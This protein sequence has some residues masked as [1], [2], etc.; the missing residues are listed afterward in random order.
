MATN[1]MQD[2]QEFIPDEELRKF[3]ELNS[4]LQEAVRNSSNLLNV[5]LELNKANNNVADSFDDYQKNITQSK[6]LVNQLVQAESKQIEIEN[7]IVTVK[8]KII[9]SDTEY[10]KAL[11]QQND[12][13]QG[14]EKSY[15]QYLISNEEASRRISQL[16]KDLAEL[17][18]AREADRKSLQQLN[19]D[20]ASEKITYDQLIKQ[21]AQVITSQQVLSARYRQTS[22]ELKEL[23]A[24]TQT[25]SGSYDNLTAQYNA[26]KRSLKSIVP[27]IEEE[28]DVRERLSA[29]LKNI[30]E[31]QKQQ[32]SATGNDTLNVGN[33]KEFAST[34]QQI[35]PALATLVRQFGSLSK[36]G[37][38]TIIGA[39]VIGF[40]A[41]NKLVSASIDTLAEGSERS[42]AYEQSIARLRGGVESLRYEFKFL[43]DT[44]ASINNAIFD[45][46]S[47][48]DRLNPN[49]KGVY[50]SILQFS[51]LNTDFLDGVIRGTPIFGKYI[52]LWDAFSK[53]LGN[54]VERG[55]EA[56]MILERQNQLLEIRRESNLAIVNLESEISAQNR[57]AREYDIYTVET[58]LE[59][60]RKQRELVS[61]LYTE[62]ISI[63]KEELD[64]LKLE[65]DSYQRLNGEV[66]RS[67]L[68][69]INQQEVAL[70][71][72]Q[73][74]RDDQLAAIGR[75]TRIVLN[76][77]AKAAKEIDT[78]AK[79]Q[80]KEEEKRRREELKAEY[81]FIQEESKL[82]LFRIQNES[83]YF[84]QIF[85]DTEQSYNDRLNALYDY[86]EKQKQAV[87]ES[88][89]T[90]IEFSGVTDSGAILIREKE[91]AELL[92]LDREFNRSLALLTR[93]RVNEEINALNELRQERQNQVNITEQAELN[94]LSAS[95]QKGIINKRT[96]ENEKLE[97][98]K[99]YAEE[100]FQEEIR[101]LNELASLSNLTDTQRFNFQKQIRQ[102]ELKY[103]QDVNNAIVK[104]DEKAAQQRE[105][106]ERQLSTL[107]KQLAQEV[108]NFLGVLSDNNFNN[109]LSALK[110]EQEASEAA[111]KA[112]IKQIEDEEKSNNISSEYAQA[113]KDDEERKNTERNLRIEEEQREILTRQAKYQKAQSLV[114]A[115][116]NI[117]EAIT[118][119]LAVTP[120]PFGAPLIA[121]IGAIGA[122]QIASILA[123]PIPEYEK[124]TEYHPGGLAIVGDGGK[125]EVVIT[126]GGKSYITNDIPQLVD[127]PKGSKVLP[128]YDEVLR[129]YSV[130]ALGNIKNSPIIITEN[131]KQLEL[132][133]ESNRLYRMNKDYS[134]SSL[135]IMYETKR[136]IQRQ[137]LTQRLN[138]SKFN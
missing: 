47:F 10:V 112:R 33:Y 70:I 92:K 52:A 130:S 129:N 53:T 115:A 90:Q 4:K 107:R 38:G 135:G 75:S 79:R 87:R 102:A 13:L 78:E 42:L 113:L 19:K 22:A 69:S 116:I 84:K 57:I 46:A 85:D 137:T 51:S 123:Q 9:D 134:Y 67:L 98:T 97:I 94:A 16:S 93:S 36:L 91:Q 133:E 118:R 31:E 121:T 82:T 20:Y 21:Q 95:Y 64:V 120:L 124:G 77:Q 138:R 43:P 72:V 54:A 44:I 89:D 7:E 24:I 127:L 28:V 45:F 73:S 111:Y 86:I 32:Q 65:A 81:Q 56:A 83:Q 48:L 8:N 18:K 6:N 126:P 29:A 1:N 96:Y 41:L 12:Q 11:K 39:I 34:L 63:I 61:D 14:N 68:D 3:D 74:Q 25:Q 103:N 109:Q 55:N 58:R 122:A 132:L 60:L 100:R 119:Q 128:S 105:Q 88:A 136:A 15:K 23:V 106:I 101:Y 50:E 5:T 35:N 108:V 17:N 2:Y 49:I 110:K 26:L 62:R 117:A 125:K 99:R 104:Q 71:R 76:E 114:S 66:S 30:R 27:D 40:T 80:A 59:A 37:V 131:K